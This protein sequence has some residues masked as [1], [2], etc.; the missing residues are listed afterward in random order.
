MSERKVIGYKMAFGW[1]EKD[2]EQDILDH[3]NEGY[4]LYG[5]PIIAQMPGNHINEYVKHGPCF[6][7]ALIKFSHD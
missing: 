3:I 7:Q 6:H 2:L 4:E 5:S 1:T